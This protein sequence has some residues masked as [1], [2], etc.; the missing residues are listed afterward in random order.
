MK[1]QMGM[2]SM[3]QS[4]FPSKQNSFNRTTGKKCDLKAQN[5][6]CQTLGSDFA[7]KWIRPESKRN[8]R[9]QYGRPETAKG[10][11]PSSYYQK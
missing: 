6:F 3:T 1:P 4:L 5:E 2:A 11:R 8:S 9:K 7:G 10:A